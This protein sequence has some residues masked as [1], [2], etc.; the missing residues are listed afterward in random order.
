MKFDSIQQ[1]SSQLLRRR[2]SVIQPKQ[3]AQNTKQANWGEVRVTE[4]CRLLI[5]QSNRSLC[6][7][8]FGHKALV[9]MSKTPFSGLGRLTWS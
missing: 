2:S 4:L 1:V 5:T 6:R 9:K 3:T 8:E 7:S